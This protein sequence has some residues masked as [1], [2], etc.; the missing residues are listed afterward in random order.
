M[1]NSGR[2]C[3]T[4]H[5][6]WYDS[7]RKLVRDVSCGDKDVYLEIEYRR[8]DCRSCGKVKTEELK[9]LADNPLYTK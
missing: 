3:G 1:T 8:V 2:E 5:H 7:K 9:W 4:L 6:G